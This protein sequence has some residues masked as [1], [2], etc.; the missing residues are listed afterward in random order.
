M[1]T[2]LPIDANLNGLEQ[3]EKRPRSLEIISYRSAENDDRLD[4][5]YEIYNNIVDYYENLVD[6]ALSIESEDLLL[7]LIHAPKSSVNTL[8]ASQAEHLGIQSLSDKQLIKM[9]AIIGKHIQKMN[10]QVYSAVEPSIT[11]VWNSIWDPRILDGDHDG[12]T[13]NFLSSFNGVVAKNLI[14]QIDKYQLAEK[15]KSDLA[16]ADND[17]SWAARAKRHLLS[18][19]SSPSHSSDRVMTK[20]QD[21]DADAFVPELSQDFLSEHIS[22]IR[23]S[24]LKQM[25]SNFMKF[26]KRVQSDIVDQS[27]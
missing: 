6:T 19:I 3:Y 25:Q 21:M 18:F 9:P 14:E 10:A 20:A 26:Y 13:L 8:L 5:E 7:N 24:L 1:T 2:A 22:T 17:A 4:Q 27:S 11:L 16:A 23:T 15:V 12:R